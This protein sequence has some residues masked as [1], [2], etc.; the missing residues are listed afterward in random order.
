VV[1]GD[2]LGA[3]ELAVLDAGAQFGLERLAQLLARLGVPDQVGQGVLAPKLVEQQL[4]V[5][6]GLDA[7]P[8]PA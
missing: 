7:L 8:P 4:P 5:A 6:L 3:A 1:P 2:R